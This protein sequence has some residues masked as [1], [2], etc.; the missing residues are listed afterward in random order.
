MPK[1]VISLYIALQPYNIKICYL[2]TLLLVST[3]TFRKAAT[4]IIPSYVVTKTNKKHLSISGKYVGS[5]SDVNVSEANY[6]WTRNL[7]KNKDRYHF[8][9]MLTFVFCLFVFVF[10]VCVV[11]LWKLKSRTVNDLAMKIIG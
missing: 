8:S 1:Y 5:K 10:F 6:I 2:W 7:E 3:P 9:F 4:I 11:S